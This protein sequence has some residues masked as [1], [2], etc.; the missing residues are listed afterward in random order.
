[1]ILGPLYKVDSKGKIRVISMEID[2]GRYRVISGLEDGAKITN[3]WTNTLPK[4]T[5]RAN[6]TTSEEQAKKEANAKYEKKL[7]ED[8]FETKE[9]AL[10]TK[11]FKPQLATESEKVDMDKVWSI[12][13]YLIQDPKL[14]GMR[15]TTQLDRY[16]S[17]TGRNVPTAAWVYTELVPFLRL[18]PDIVLDGELYNHTYRDNFEDLMSLARRDKLSDE[19]ESNARTL[20]QF[21]VYDMVDFNNPNITA[22][23]RKEWLEENL[24]TSNRIKLVRYEKVYDKQELKTANK[25]NLSLGYEGS[26]VRTPTS[27]YK[28]GRSKNMLKI[29]EFLTAEFTIIDILPGKGNRTDIAGRVIVDVNG[30]EVGCGIRGSWEYCKALLESADKYI[31]KEATIRFFEWTKDKSLRFPVCIDVARWDHE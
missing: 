4:N 23:E 9:E 3:K 30:I 25:Y 14:D 19:D 29:K 1:M 5:G 27:T 16:Q 7:R 22:I 20:L 31:N 10:A 24:P 15:L 28:Q 11:L 13:D 18:H 21:H 8:Y 6:A 26:V 12:N 2:H 17:R